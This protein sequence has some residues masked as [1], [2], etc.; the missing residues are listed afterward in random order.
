VVL[1]IPRTVRL[2]AAALDGPVEHPVGFQPATN[3]KG[4]RQDDLPAA[5]LLP[6]SYS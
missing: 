3:Q 6:A 4:S 1:V 5:F 2:A